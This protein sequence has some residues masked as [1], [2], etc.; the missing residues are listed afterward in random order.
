M[1]GNGGEGE[2]TGPSKLRD[3]VVAEAS[4]SPW[5][6]HDFFLLAVNFAEEFTNGT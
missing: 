1:R 3:Q 5:E 2:R 6:G 4:K